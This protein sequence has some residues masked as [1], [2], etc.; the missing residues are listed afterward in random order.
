MK[1]HLQKV[2]YQNI[3]PA[4]RYRALI[5]LAQS[6]TEPQV[7]VKPQTGAE[8]QTDSQR[9]KGSFAKGLVRKYSSSSEI[10]NHVTL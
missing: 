7:R 8:S 5:N 3:H 1:V 6:G 4:L 10:F 2:W 9:H